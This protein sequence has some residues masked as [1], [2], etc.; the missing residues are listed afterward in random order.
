MGYGPSS[1]YNKAKSDSKFRKCGKESNKFRGHIDIKAA[2][3]L[4]RNWI[5]GIN[6]TRASDFSY[7]QRY[8][9]GKKTF[10]YSTSNAMR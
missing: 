4:S 1:I 5:V 2:E 10:K 9:M 3:R 7:M 6:A 8:K